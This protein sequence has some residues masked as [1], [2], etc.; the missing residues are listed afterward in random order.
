MMALNKY[1]NALRHAIR[2]DMIAEMAETW[3][4]SKLKA[5]EIAW[6]DC[7]AA[8]IELEALIMAAVGESDEPRDR[9][10]NQGQGR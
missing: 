8:R 10:E 2:K 7:K 5:C 6:A 9:T 4:G 3:E 1:D